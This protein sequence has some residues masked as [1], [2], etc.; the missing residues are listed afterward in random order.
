VGN[1]TNHN[2]SFSFSSIIENGEMKAIQDFKKPII[3]T[4]MVRVVI[5]LFFLGV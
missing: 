3:T 1:A 4:F 5:E 2:W